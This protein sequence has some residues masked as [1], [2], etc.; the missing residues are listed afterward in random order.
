M[1]R[2]DNFGEN[3]DELDLCRRLVISVNYDF[4]GGVMTATNDK[5]C[6]NLGQIMS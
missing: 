6:K 1:V 2:V 4:G 3:V 5:Y